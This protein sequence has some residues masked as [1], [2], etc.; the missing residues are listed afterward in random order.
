MA[1]LP[2]TAADLELFADLY[3]AAEDIGLAPC[4]IGAGAIQI[5]GASAWEVRLARRTLDWDFAVRVDSWGEYEALRSALTS[6]ERFRPMNT[7]H[8]F[9]HQR[10]GLLDVIPYGGIEAPPG[11]LAWP[12]GH[13]MG[14]A[15]LDAL[16]RHS[17]RIKLSQ[18]ELRLATLPAV[19]GLK[20]LAYRDRGPRGIFRDIQ[21]A[22]ALLRD[23][24]DAA[25]DQRIQT[26]CM[27]RFA[28]G[29]LSY[30]EAGAYL[31]GRD[32]GATFQV[33]ALA[34]ITS[35]LADLESD[36]NPLLGDIQ[37]SIHA[38]RASIRDRLEAFRTGIQDASQAAGPSGRG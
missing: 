13:V 10:G 22:Y 2:Y 30:G 4:L 5:G 28:S 16:D 33:N 3:Q 23:A 7:P 32:V 37:R 18:V 24:E 36:G 14:T 31:L 15:G 12:D 34:P 6:D 21:D 1:E 27:D 35:L 38:H 19:V 11:V 29:R 26:E 20:I 25:A 8:R 9:S 17:C